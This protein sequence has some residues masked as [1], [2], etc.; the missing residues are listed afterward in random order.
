MLLAISLHGP[1]ISCLRHVRETFAR[2]TNVKIEGIIQFQLIQIFSP[3]L[4]NLLRM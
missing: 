2:Y 4:A 1:T 3:A